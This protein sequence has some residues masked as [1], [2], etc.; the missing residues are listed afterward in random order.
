MSTLILIPA[1]MGSTR[2]P[3]KPLA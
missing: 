2:L 1:R 3:G